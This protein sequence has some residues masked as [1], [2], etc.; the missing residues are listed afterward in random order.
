MNSRVSETAARQPDGQPQSTVVSGRLR[1]SHPLQWYVDDSPR[2]L[3]QGTRLA[4]F[5]NAPVPRAN[6]LLP[7][8]HAGVDAWSSMDVGNGVPSRHSS[9]PVQLRAQAP[10]QGNGIDPGPG[11][12]KQQPQ[13]ARQG[14]DNHTLNAGVPVRQAQKHRQNVAV[15]RSAQ[16]SQRSA[17]TT[18][19]SPRKSALYDAAFAGRLRA[20]QV[21]M[22]P[23]Q[24]ALSG[25]QVA[26]LAVATGRIGSGVGRPI[27]DRLQDGSARLGEQRIEM[28]M[29]QLGS[30][31]VQGIVQQVA[32]LNP[33]AAAVQVHGGHYDVVARLNPWI[34]VAGGVIT[35]ENT[36]NHHQTSPGAGWVFVT[37]PNL[38]AGGVD[39]KKALVGQ[40]WGSAG[41]GAPAGSAATYTT[42]SATFNP[43][44]MPPAFH[45]LPPDRLPGVP[46]HYAWKGGGSM[47]TPY[48]PHR[49][50]IAAPSSPG[51]NVDAQMIGS[52]LTYSSYHNDASAAAPAG[53]R[54]LSGYA[55]VAQSGHTYG[56]QRNYPMTN[57][58]YEDPSSRRHGRGHVVDH[59]DGDATTTASSRN[60]V[61]EDRNFNSGARNH[62][63]QGLRPVGGYYQVRYEYSAVPTRVQD[64]TAVPT[65]EHFMI[66][67]SAGAPEYVAVDNTGGYPAD[68][69]RAAASGSRKLPSTFP[70][71]KNF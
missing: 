10:M 31:S 40:A 21:S 2:Q 30:A 70:F 69:S 56:G 68:R 35:H 64:G 1:S 9:K 60:Y 6:G 13:E 18:G 19:M 42:P 66:S 33:R 24:R 29:P 57:D 53:V 4:Q 51:Y 26:E 47:A 55:E 15:E 22:A 28:P 50:P 27:A 62:M 54:V 41:G 16:S 17:Q 5:K 71:S 67:P 11:Q 14:N 3:A 12:G 36:T 45:V 52:R 63:V 8:V 65:T 38:V 7:P 59:A 23:I 48:I 49:D 25:S 46:Q 43:A 20:D 39:R 58:D 37:Y 61:P 34:K 44:A 32:T